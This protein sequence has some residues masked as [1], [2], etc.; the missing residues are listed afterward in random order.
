MQ[1]NLVIIPKSR[2]PERLKENIDLFDFELT[3][4]EMEDINKLNRNA[5]T[6]DPML[7]PTMG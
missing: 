6:V 4:A 5:R 1:H 2:N 7:I 3:N